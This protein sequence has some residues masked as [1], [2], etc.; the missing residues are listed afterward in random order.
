MP[1]HAQ[2][3][4]EAP[5]QEET[6]EVEIINSDVLHFEERDGKKLTKLRGNVQLKQDQMLMFCDSASLD[7]DNNQ[8]EAWGHVHIQNDTVDAYSDYLNYDSK[9]KLHYRRHRIPR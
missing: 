2:K 7:K 5:P 4:T 9:I 8:M 3:A 6:K 1:V